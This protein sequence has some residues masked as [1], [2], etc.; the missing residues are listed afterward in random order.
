MI[1]FKALKAT[2]CWSRISGGQNHF[3]FRIFN[4]FTFKFSL[5]SPTQHSVKDIGLEGIIY[6]LEVY[7]YFLV[8]WIQET[9]I[10]SICS[11]IHPRKNVFWVRHRFSYHYRSKKTFLEL[12][13]HFMQY[14]NY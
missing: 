2:S 6:F 10:G 4:L 8:L 9:M 7:L 13:L 3:N 1:N 5:R 11:S 14:D 12:S